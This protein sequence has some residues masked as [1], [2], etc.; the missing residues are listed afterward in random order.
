MEI[1][2]FIS[3]NLNGFSEF[4]IVSIFPIMFRYPLSGSVWV[5][6]SGRKFGTGGATGIY[7]EIY[8]ARG[9]ERLQR[10]VG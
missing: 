1:V 7:K 6:Y 8:S 3:P 9:G 5:Q 10:T 4:R 2:K